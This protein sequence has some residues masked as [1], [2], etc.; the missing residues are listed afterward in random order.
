MS[1]AQKFYKVFVSSTYENLKA[2]RNQVFDSLLKANCFPVGMEHFPGS[3][4]NSPDLIKKYIDQCDYFLVV[5]AGMYGSL[6]PETEVSYTEWEYEYAIAQKIPCHAFVFRNVGHLLGEKIDTRYRSQLEAFHQRLRTSGREVK[7]Y[8]NVYDLGSKV[9]HAF[10]SAPQNSPAIG[11]VRARR[12]AVPQYS[13]IVGGWKL[14]R[15]NNENWNRCDVVKIYT[16]ETFVWTCIDRTAKRNLQLIMGQY[17]THSYET[18]IIELPLK[19]SPKMSFIGEEQEFA[20]LELSEQHLKT[21]STRANGSV[22]EEDFERIDWD[23]VGAAFE[24]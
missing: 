15:S 18:Q 7:F 14:V 5:T 19:T 20:V 17:Q 21:V 13:A 9:L 6:V 16:D 12:E 22:I 11:W 1:G 10:Q 3:D 4:A 8:E 23:V 24:A 2:E